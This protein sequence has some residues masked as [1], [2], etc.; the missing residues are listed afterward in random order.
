VTQIRLGIFAWV[1]SLRDRKRTLARDAFVAAA[2]DLAETQGF[3]ETTVGQ[4]ADRA[5]MSPATFFRYFGSKEDV[6][7][8]G[9]IE[10]LPIVT[11]A[12]TAELV[13]H[14]DPW[15]A[16]TIAARLATRELVGVD[17][18]LAERVIRLWMTE[19]EV[20]ARYVDYASR[21]EQAIAAIID[22]HGTDPATR[23]HAATLAVSVIGAFRIA[24]QLWIEHG[25]DLL[26]QFD[27]VL[28]LVGNGLAAGSKTARHP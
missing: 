26:E 8:V 7:F 14:D 15:D 12:L 3:A 28:E 9:P 11:D 17:R 25:E 19:P 5:V 23:R 13:K 27:A 1:S 20:R 4:I 6:F 24:A 21:W 16:V 22:Q 18:P 10:L 2:L